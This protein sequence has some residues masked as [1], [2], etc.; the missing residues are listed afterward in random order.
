MKLKKLFIGVSA[1]LLVAQASAHNRWILPS[2]FNLS[3]DKG[4]WIVV[5]VTASNETFNVDKPMGAEKMEVIAPS[6]K[7][8]FP[9]SS[10]RGQRKSVVDIHLEDS[11]TYQLKM[12]GEASYWTGYKIKGEKEEQWLRNVNKQDRKKKLPKGA[13]DVKTIESSG[14]ILTYVTLNS[15]SENFAVS[16]QGLELVPVTHPSD[17]AQGEEANFSFTLNGKAQAG[18]EVEIIRE[19]VRYRNDPESLKLT[20]DAKGNINFTL[21]QAGR[22]LLMAE[23]ESEVKDYELADV[24]A[25]KVFLTFE[26]VLD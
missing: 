24:I 23:Y 9:G 15:P 13:Y 8:V 20:S 6:G 26:A 19:G 4:E 10:Y 12:G 21:A 2:H 11:G 1:L 5:D 22:Y 3:N 17:I 16:N 14:S 25:G 18:V 7:R